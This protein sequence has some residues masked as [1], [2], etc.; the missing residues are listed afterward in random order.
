MGEACFEG[1][2]VGARARGWSFVDA[3]WRWTRFTTDATWAQWAGRATVERLRA[4]R[5]SRLIAWTRR[6]S[7]FYR[8]HWSGAPARAAR[9]EDLPPA[10][11]A[12]LMARFDDWVTDPAVKLRDVA[13]FVADPGR[14][15]Q[16]FLGRYAVFSSSGTTGIPGLVLHDADALAVY[17]ALGAVRMGALAPAWHWDEALAAHRY[18][19]IAAT[20]GHFAGV[21]GWER[22]RALNPWFEA[23]A[24]VFPV[25][26]PLHELCAALDRFRPTVIAS[27]A[28]VLRA[29]AAERDAGRLAA[30]PSMLWYGG[31]WLAPMARAHIER[32]FAC[33]VAGDYGAS[34]FP[35]I[36]FECERGALHVNDDWVVLEPVDE[37]FRPVPPDTPSASVLLTNLANRVQPI[38]RYELGDSVTRVSK[39]CACGRPFPVIRVDGR[40]DEILRLHDARGREV[41]VLPMAL[42]T[43]VE[44][45][46]RLH[47]F[48]VVQTGPRELHVRV[49]APGREREASSGVKRALEGFLAR[50]GLAGVAVR[51]GA[52]AV[53]AHP[54]SGKFRQVWR[55]KARH[56]A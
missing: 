13:R 24:R 51:V 26:A 31:E 34:E 45:G 9:L 40:R 22:L 11:K 38:V 5:L 30:A 7:A 52:G 15:G 44:E 23:N 41:P 4:D 28:T 6:H 49:E 54:V 10:H 36:A 2:A 37:D 3:M 18:A 1:R 47:R 19:L 55:E 25:T 29:L 42:T 50:Q 12:A 39:P 32:A 14:L 46:S 56:P 8:D 16:P 43:A 20:E 21:V 53:A 33:P 17:E 27:Y 35:N 48:Q